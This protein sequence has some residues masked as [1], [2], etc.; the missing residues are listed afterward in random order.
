M[1]HSP[2]QRPLATPRLRGAGVAGAV[3][4]SVAGIAQYTA[5]MVEEDRSGSDPADARRLDAVAAARALRRIA[6]AREPPW[7]HCEVARRLNERLVPIRAEPRRIIDWW[8][9]TGAGEAVLRATYP[10]AEIVP[11]EAA[12]TLAIVAARSKPRPW[13]S[14]GRA[15]VAP[16]GDGADDTDI[17]TAQL[18]WANMALHLVR[19]PPT[20]FARWHG[21]LDVDGVAAFSCPG[22][23]T[24]REL[25]SLYD[26]C[27]WPAP[28]AAFIDMHD[29]GDMMVHAGF[30]EPVLDQET[31]TLRWRNAEAL[32]VELAQLGGNTAPDRFR[33]LRTPA[34][35]RR[36]LAA[37]A[38][39]AEADG[40]ISLS[41]EVAFGHGFKAAPRRRASE[42]TAVPLATMRE[43][44]RRPR[45]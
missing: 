35:R 20:L 18:V 19:D 2:G 10:R 31:L 43:M 21:L 5:R 8:A 37:L 33:A 14:L 7:L 27:G 30:A 42:P 3:G 1:A 23:G 17:G 29:L 44:M 12:P 40:R 34:W 24:L 9:A 15:P 4:S 11:I 39:R 45:R 36:L 25:R 38:R 6:A 26:E 13:W 22:P 32:L 28:T 16:M 41:V